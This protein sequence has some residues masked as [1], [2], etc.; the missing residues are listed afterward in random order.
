MYSTITTFIPHYS[1][2]QFHIIPRW[3]TLF[4][5]RPFLFHVPRFSIPR[6]VTCNC[7]EYNVYSTQ[8]A[9]NWGQSPSRDWEA[10][11][12]LFHVLFHIIPHN[13]TWAQVWTPD[14]A[15]ASGLG[16]YPDEAEMYLGES[17]LPLEDSNG[18]STVKGSVISCVHTLFSWNKTWNC[19]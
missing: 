13:S 8:N 4:H 16:K 2:L 7:V 14:L 18:N 3:W 11:N 12:G 17:D 9:W 1:K 19:K 10:K 15:G 5:I 6:L